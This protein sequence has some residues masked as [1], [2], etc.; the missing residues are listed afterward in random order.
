MVLDAAWETPISKQW[1][2]TAHHV[3]MRDRDVVSNPAL[4]CRVVAKISPHLLTEALSVSVVMCKRGSAHN[5]S[6]Y[7]NFTFKV[8]K[9]KRSCT[10]KIH[11]KKKKMEV[12][13]SE[14]EIWVWDGRLPIESTL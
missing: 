14:V 1:G 6:K 13:F 3:A 10:Q 9:K 2:P 4:K 7:L 11:T 5:K 12:L 8:I